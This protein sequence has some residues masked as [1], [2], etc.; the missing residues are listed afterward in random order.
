M[1]DVTLTSNIMVLTRESSVESATGNEGISNQFSESESEPVQLGQCNKTVTPE[2]PIAMP[3]AFWGMK[4]RSLDNLERILESFE[5]EGSIC[6]AN[7]VA[8]LASLL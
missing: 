8:A 6:K 1:K 5:V 4:S 3:D 7:N 2:G